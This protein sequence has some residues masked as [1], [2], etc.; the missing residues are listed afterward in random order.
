MPGTPPVY[1]GLIGP[2][3]PPQGAFLS[4]FILQ[5][6]QPVRFRSGAFQLKGSDG[7]VWDITGN[8]YSVCN[9]LLFRNLHLV[10]GVTYHVTVS[11][12]K[13]VADDGVTEMAGPA[14]GD[15]IVP[16]ALPDTTAPR[17]IL[18][19]PT[20][21]RQNGL[22]LQFNEHVVVGNGYIRIY[23]ADGSLFYATSA[24]SITWSESGRVSIN[25]PD[26]A[27]GAS[28]YVTIDPDAILDRSG[29]A[30]KGMDTKDAFAFTAPG[31]TSPPRLF[32]LTPNPN[33][34]LAARGS[35]IV[36]YFNEA[37]TAASG[38][39]AISGGGKNRS[40]DVRDTSQVSI[41]GKVVTINLAEDLEYD[42]AYA[43]TVPIGIVA[44]LAGNLLMQDLASFTF[45]TE[46]GPLAPPPP[47]PPFAPNSFSSMD[48]LNLW[49]TLILSFDR[50]LTRGAGNII[51]HNA[52]GSVFETIPVTDLERVYLQAKWLYL[53]LKTPLAPQSGYYIALDAG[54]LQDAD[55][56]PSQAVTARETLAF[57]TKAAWPMTEIPGYQSITLNM[58]GQS[59]IIAAYRPPQ[60]SSL[61]LHGEIIATSSEL[62]P[63]LY[64]LFY[65]SSG[66]YRDAI[67]ENRGRIQAE[68]PAMRVY[69]VEAGAHAPEFYN[70]P[71]GSIEA[72]GFEAVAVRWNGDVSSITNE[73]LIYAAA[74]TRAVGLEILGATRGVINR[75]VIRADQLPNSHASATAINLWNAVLLNSGSVFSDETGVLFAGDL[76]HAT[77]PGEFRIVNSGEISAPIAISKIGSYGSPN[78]ISRILNEAGGVIQGEIL[79]KTGGNEVH[80]LGMIT[81]SIYFG[82][83]AS[84]FEGALG[85]FSGRIFSGAGNDFLAAGAGDARLSSGN[86][87]DT[88]NGGLGTDFLDGGGNVDTAVFTGNRAAYAISHGDPGFF[89]I[90]GP[91]G[92]DTLTGIEYARFD[93]QRVRLLPGEGRSLVAG[94]DPASY[95]NAIRDFDGNAL[96]GQGTLRID[97]A[98]GALVNG[99]AWDGVSGWTLAGVADVNGNG[100]Q[101]HILFN[102]QIGRWAEVTVQFDGMVYFDNHGW[103]GDTRVVGIYV[104]PLVQSG[105]VQA[106]SLDDSQRRFTNDLFIGNLKSVLNAGDYDKDGGQEV[107]FSLTDG[108]AYLHAYMHADGNIRYANYQSPQQVQDYLAANNY[109]GSLSWLS[110]APPEPLGE[111]PV[112]WA[113]EALPMAVMEPPLSFD[114][115]T[116]HGLL[117]SASG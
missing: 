91:D 70:G 76:A 116:S 111:A 113:D 87:A 18:Q 95:M 72:A 17:L 69:G 14:S 84:R 114:L 115:L 102:N 8:A 92:T 112:L 12:D 53:D 88:L 65:S 62:L 83:D 1:L 45:R 97:P 86:G 2:T 5:F 35:N 59:G 94:A 99:G 60:E 56:Q 80:N 89:I 47:P 85:G 117:A 101:S 103:A 29:N 4:F 32:D 106:G 82:P 3:V 22:E 63:N 98:T 43:V 6:D 104:D 31:D 11:P 9:G 110:A 100:L 20:G 55:G 30:Y 108:T 79:L 25:T 107:Y 66:T 68:A 109:T 13:V 49:P 71:S 90:T 67:F 61:V 51:V 42:T 40:V 41:S 28:Y 24:A 77:N 38:I 96:K 36:L 81:G 21:A 64:G 7:T 54:V 34:S 27:Y 57:A 23:N 46:R 74:T 10:A 50:I 58:A 37:V 105:L 39:I 52:D 93:D 16:A 19:G 15:F 26:Y 33:I 75:G 73:G 78:A 48:D 44:D